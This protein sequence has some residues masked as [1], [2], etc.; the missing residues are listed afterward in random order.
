M[1]VCQCACLCVIVSVCA[2]V[3]V[4]VRVLMCVRV[5]ALVVSHA[6]VVHGDPEVSGSLLPLSG[7]EEEE[8]G[9]GETWKHLLPAVWLTREGRVTLIAQWRS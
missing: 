6:A 8:R 5:C 9:A 7:G 2:Y 3:I 1:S 4:C